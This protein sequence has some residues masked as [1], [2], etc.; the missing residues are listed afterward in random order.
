MEVMVLKNFMERLSTRKVDE[1]GRV[2]LPSEVRNNGWGTGST[3]SL[4]HADENTII[5]QLSEK[6]Q[7]PVCIIC[8]KHEKAVT[9]NGTEICS[10]CAE[11]IKSLYVS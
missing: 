2:V 8:K 5:M 6:Y 3:V 7:G 1:L 4:Y 10:E 9:V 11:K